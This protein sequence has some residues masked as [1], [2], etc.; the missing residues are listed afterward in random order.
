MSHLYG[1]P[2]ECFLNIRLI[3][4]VSQENLSLGFLTRSHD[5]ADFI[6]S[7]L[8]CRCMRTSSQILNTGKF[9]FF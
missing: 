9:P 2:K 8:Y 4:A 3:L 6:V 1:N 5:A 7:S